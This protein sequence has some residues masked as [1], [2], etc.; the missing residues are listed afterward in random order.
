M[1]PLASRLGGCLLAAGA[2][3]PSAAFSQGPLQPPGPPAPTM[4]SLDQLHS[5]LADI[6]ETQEK[7]FP[8]T[9][10]PVTITRPGSYYFIGSVNFS[11][12]TGN[13]ITVA[14]SDVTIDLNGF[15]LS[16][17]PGVTGN[18]IQIN[19]N[20]RNVTV[21]NGAI[22]GTSTVTVS[23]IPPNRTWGA[24]AGG[25]SN[26]IDTGAQTVNCRFSDLRISGCRS[27][28]ISAADGVVVE[29]VTAAHNVG[30]GINVGTGTVEKCSAALNFGSGIVASAG[31]VTNSTAADNNQTG[32]A[33]HAVVHCAASG[34]GVNGLAGNTVNNS[35]SVSN[36][37]DGIVADAVT[38]CVANSNGRTGIHAV[39][40]A[41]TNSVVNN[42]RSDGILATNGVVAFCRAKNNNVAGNGS[43]NIDAGGNAVLTGNNANP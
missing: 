6:N 42:N 30:H 36:K 35:S 27:V 25:F 18:G 31:S 9:S 23:G 33:G 37:Q 16:S 26:A 1:F 38:N 5:A 39:D 19:N 22:A 32:I 17:S 43:L 28:G 41:V 13:A 20:V 4:N 2:I 14:V 7:R 15:T 12:T 34:N 29:G 8:I 11:G 40:G 3:L 24:T 10:V 21:R